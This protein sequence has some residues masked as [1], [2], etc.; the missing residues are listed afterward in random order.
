MMVL[1]AHDDEIFEAADD[2]DRAIADEAEITGAQKWT[3]AALGDPCA[4][5]RRGVGGA[6]P[7]AT[8]DV[9]TLDPDLAHPI[10]GAAAAVRRIDDLD[11]YTRQRLSVA[12]QSLRIGVCGR[13]HHAALA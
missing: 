1:A 2:V 4:E 3:F 7:V 9:C 6:I 11:G 10:G 8:R 5:R 13:W 12:D